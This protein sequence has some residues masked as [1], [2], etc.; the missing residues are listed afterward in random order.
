MN[1]D[2]CGADVDETSRAFEGK[3]HASFYDDRHA[4]FKMNFLADIGGMLDFYLFLLAATDGQ[5]LAAA[6]CLHPAALH[7]KMVVLLN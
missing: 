1:G 7:V 4:R 3:L 5:G 2:A 6:N